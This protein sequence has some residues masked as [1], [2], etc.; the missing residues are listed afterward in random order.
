MKRTRTWV[1]T[2]PVAAACGDEDVRSG[3]GA[4]EPAPG[5]R[6]AGQAAESK[7]VTHTIGDTIV[8]RTV[9]GRAWDRDAEL[10]PELSIGELDGPDELLF[11]KITSLAV[12]DGRNL[13]VLDEQAAEVRVFDD[14]GAH[15][16]TLGGRGEGPGELKA[17]GAVGVL[18]DGRVL[19]RDPGNM[20]VQVFGPRPGDREEWHHDLGNLFVNRPLWTDRQGRSYLIALDP[21]KSALSGPIIIIVLEP[22]GT[23]AETLSPPHA[24]FEQ[25]YVEAKRDSAMVRGTVSTPVPFTPNAYWTLHPNGGF[26]SG[27]S[28]GYSFDLQVPHGVLRLERAHEPVPVT[29]AE[30]DYHRDL[31]VRIIRRSIEGWRWDG[32]SIPKTKPPFTGLRAGRDGRIWVTLSTEGRS[33]END[34]HDPND[35]FSMA[36]LWTYPL[37]FDVFEPDGTYLGTV[38]A[39]EDFSLYPE[40]V[41]DGDYVWAVTRDDLGVE[42]VVR[43]R[44][45]MEAGS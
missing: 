39:P 21:S 20:R 4:G 1:A 7:V 16:R 35:P 15:L 11:G 30:A 36:T 18:T 31:A 23:P 34:D 37:R 40:P 27:V 10:V 13:Y 17:P 22:D 6:V 5:A 3:E 28:S 24:D 25:P 29:G 14:A 41:F 43:W 38:N 12:D 42:R 2:L 45:E 8:V 44:V 19:V 9:S 32:P 33:V 26:L